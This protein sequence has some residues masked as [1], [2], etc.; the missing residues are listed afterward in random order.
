DD[1]LHLGIDD[2][3]FGNLENKDLNREMII[4]LSNDCYQCKKKVPLLNY[5]DIMI[6][7]MMTLI[8]VSLISTICPADQA[9]GPRNKRPDQ[10][11]D[12]SKIIDHLGSKLCHSFMEAVIGA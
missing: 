12:L 4:K 1:L 6:T 11:R 8:M 5:C 9:L 10:E 3:E 7:I 2:S